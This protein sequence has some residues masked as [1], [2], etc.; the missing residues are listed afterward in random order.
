MVKEVIARDSL[1][2]YGVICF[3]KSKSYKFEE[4][5]LP[6]GKKYYTINTQIGQITFYERDLRRFF[7]VE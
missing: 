7:F 1:E 3:E 5:T 6:D 2:K 4:F